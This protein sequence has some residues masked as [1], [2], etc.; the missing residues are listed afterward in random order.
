MQTHY[1]KLN[2]EGNKSTHSLETTFLRFLNE[3]ITLRNHRLADKTL[4]WDA[5]GQ[6]LELSGEIR[7]NKVK[8]LFPWL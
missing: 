2:R 6:E 8:I 1:L 7:H 3:R 5:I 4:G